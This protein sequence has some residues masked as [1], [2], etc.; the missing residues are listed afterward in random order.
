MFHKIPQK[1]VSIIVPTPSDSDDHLLQNGDTR[2]DCPRV[3]IL[4]WLLD[5]PYDKSVPFSLGTEAGKRWDT[6]CEG[7]LISGITHENERD[8]TRERTSL[9]DYIFTSK[10][11]DHVE[12]CSLRKY[13]E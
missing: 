8:N 2:S 11:F 13:Y 5:Y 6:G 9:F 10:R 1:N 7:G 3:G 4:R 12:T